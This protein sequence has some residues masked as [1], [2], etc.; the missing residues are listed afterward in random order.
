MKL[1]PGAPLKL[2]PGASRRSRAHF[3]KSASWDRFPHNVYNE[4]KIDVLTHS[5]ITPVTKVN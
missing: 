3:Y 5:T 1:C 4:L 2:C